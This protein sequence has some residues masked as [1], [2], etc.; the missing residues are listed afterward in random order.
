MISHKF[1]QNKPIKKDQVQL[2]TTERYFEY[3][4]MQKLSFHIL[5]V[6]LGNRGISNVFY[7]INVYDR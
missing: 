4:N 1:R 7:G 6:K 5:Q 3:T 2:C